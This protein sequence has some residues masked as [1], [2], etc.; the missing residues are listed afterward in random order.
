[1][2]ILKALTLLLLAS[3]AQADEFATWMCLFGN[4]PISV[5]TP[6]D[7]IA[8][9]TLTIEVTNGLSFPM[10]AVAIDF[11][12]SSAS[13][14]S[15]FE[16]SIVIPFPAPMQAGET[17]ILTAFLS[18]SEAEISG[19]IDHDGLSARASVAN[20]LDEDDRR[21]VLRENLGPSFRVFWPFQLGSAQTCE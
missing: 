5:I 11:T 19:L 16:Q 8:D 18:L 9:G 4:V 1:M 12:L 10:N 2:K 20:V 14:G 7:T 3:P 15:T 6:A 13:E 21:M 17:R